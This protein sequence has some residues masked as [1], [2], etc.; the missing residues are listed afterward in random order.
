MLFR[1]WRRPWNLT[2]YAAL[3]GLLVVLAS[4]HALPHDLVLLAVPVWLTVRLQRDQILP[5]LLPLWVLADLALLVDLR[6]L[7]I[8]VAPIAL[9]LVLGCLVWRLRRIEPLR[10]VAA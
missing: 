9:T 4:P 2:A 3:A 1:S 10:A 8:P 6:G 7:P 5:N